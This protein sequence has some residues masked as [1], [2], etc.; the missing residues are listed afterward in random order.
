LTR[1]WWAVDDVSAPKPLGEKRKWLYESLSYRAGDI[2]IGVSTEFLVGLFVTHDFGDAFAIASG[3]GLLEN[4]LNS[5]FYLLNR[6]L[7]HR[8]PD[9]DHE[10]KRVPHQGQGDLRA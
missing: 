5:V 1:F 6:A 4:A 9:S 8:V 7:W 10:H 2:L 3:V